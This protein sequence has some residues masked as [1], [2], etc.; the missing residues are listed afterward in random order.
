M[1]VMGRGVSEDVLHVGFWRF[2][3]VFV[4]VELIRIISIMGTKSQATRT[5]YRDEI[6]E[7]LA[8]ISLLRTS[9]A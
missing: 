1:R 2:F 5:V 8:L 3:I 4:L 7:D 6:H 9:T